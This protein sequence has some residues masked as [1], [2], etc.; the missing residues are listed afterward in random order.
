MNKLRL[1]DYKE[2]KDKDV[3][4]FEMRNDNNERRKKTCKYGK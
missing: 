2:R 1:I 3:I 4:G